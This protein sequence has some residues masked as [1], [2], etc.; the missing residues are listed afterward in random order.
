MIL[1]WAVC[2][3]CVVF[4]D[5]HPR[6]TH[7]IGDE[8][9]QK[10]L[11]DT[12]NCLCNQVS[13]ICDGYNNS[14]IRTVRHT[15]GWRDCP[16]MAKMD[17]TTRKPL[18]CRAISDKKRQRA[19]L[20]YYAGEE[21]S[22]IFDTLPDTGDDF[23]TA[24]TKL[25]VYFGPKKNVEFEIFT[26]RQAKQNPGETMNSYHSRLRQLATTCEF[27]DVDKEVKS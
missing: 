27:T 26:F 24:K 9:R 2:S 18:C 13:N 6:S 22:E 3:L 20:L 23:E 17:Q 15:R 19:L 25:H 5:T 16:T 4:C 10:L 21:V 7:Y 8:D 1:T 11:Q 12:H 14:T